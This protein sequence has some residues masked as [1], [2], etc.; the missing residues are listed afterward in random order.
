MPLRCALIHFCGVGVGVCAIQ[1]VRAMIKSHQSQVRETQLRCQQH[2]PVPA[3]QLR[4]ARGGLDY[5][6]HVADVPHPAVVAEQP[7]SLLRHEHRVH[8]IPAHPLQH[9]PVLCHQE[10]GPVFRVDLV[11]AKGHTLDVFQDVLPAAG[12]IAYDGAAH[13]LSNFL[14]PALA[15]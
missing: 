13:E 15:I 5:G 1:A 14:E 6:L 10:R 9:V 4:A 8:A 2:A 12:P 7:P 11:A 3:E